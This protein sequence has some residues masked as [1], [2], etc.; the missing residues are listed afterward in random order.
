M[1]DSPDTHN[2]HGNVL[3]DLGRYRDALSCYERALA[4][5]PD[6]A[7]AHYNRGVT[8]YGLGRHHD[9]LQS[10]DRAL[11]LK[12]DHAAAWNNR[13]TA[14]RELQRCEEALQSYERAIAAK[15]DHAGAHSNRGAALHALERY[16]E[17]L[18]CFER[19]IGVAPDHADTHANR[20]GTLTALGR[21]D[22]ALASL[23]RALAIDPGC[24][25]AHFNRGVTLANLRRFP[26]ALACVDHTLAL[27][28]R[29]AATWRCRGDV[30]WGLRRFEE[31]IE[32]YAQAL[33][34]DPRSRFLSGE[35]RH[36][37]MRICDWNALESDL[38]KI[39][40]GIERDEA[41]V[42][43][44]V[45]H[46]LL[47]SPALQR[48]AA[49][50]FAR[51]KIRPPTT[52]PPLPRRVH[53]EKI[54]IGYFSADFRTH[55]VSLLA[56]GLFEAHDRSHFEITALA[57]G[58]DTRDE[59]RTR[60]E[61]AFDRFVSVG[62]MTDREVA[63][64]A[65]RLEFDIAVD[66]GGYTRNCRSGILAL[67]A[68]PLQV[69]YLGYLGTMGCE[70]IDYLIADPVL[71]P[72]DSRQHYSEKIAYLSS[73]Q[74]NDSKRPLPQRSLTRAELGLPAAGFVFCCFNNTYKITPETFDCWMRILAAVPESVLFLLGDGATAERNL[75]REAGA[76][77]VAPERLIFGPSLPL[78][79]YLARFGAAD[80]FLDTLPYNAG[81]TA[82]DA[83]WAGLPVLTL[84]GHAFAARM[85]AS[86]LT[87]A[88]L[89]ELIA[90]DRADYERLAVSVA[91]DPKRLADLKQKVA[92]NRRRCALFD[93]A[94][95]TRNLE[96]LYRR[97][98]DRHVSGLLPA[99]LDP[100]PSTVL[101]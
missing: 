58:P 80:L 8:L 63:L 5:D 1:P 85:A 101:P 34:L 15:P 31:T 69:S 27:G 12:P 84:P 32:S 46:A 43:P 30:L 42:P 20:G 93:T 3:R 95:F 88:G 47:D 100:E 92:V 40:A 22:E 6:F 26:E 91:S 53:R 61:A 21:F 18:E 28:R 54:R 60:L 4:L 98:Y 64:L 11:A 38:A 10:Y 77:G 59:L 99:H 65:R 29:D 72:P 81:T 45:L 82:S 13:G 71:V 76:R 36:V 78:D 74:V 51:E 35:C 52:L 37:R 86:V 16:E 25:D 50:I 55:A 17:A 67:R 90:A 49:T 97:M 56:A 83:L 33:A 70:F 7:E 79:Q 9:A 24:V 14:L 48:S 75:R 39:S 73:Y 44:F 94:G 87:A 89:P 66:L 68:A 41:V 23:D 62:D 2:N 57:L 96:A 19:A